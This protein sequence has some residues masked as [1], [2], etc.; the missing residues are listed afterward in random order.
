MLSEPRV[1]AALFHVNH[2]PPYCPRPLLLCC[3]RPSRAELPCPAEICIASRGRLA[4]P[5]E[6]TRL[7][8]PC[9]RRD[10]LNPS[11]QDA[12]KAWAGAPSSG[13]SAAGLPSI[14]AV[15]SMAA[16]AEESAGAAGVVSR[17]SAEVARPHPAPL[18]AP[19]K[20]LPRPPP[21]GGAPWL[22]IRP[23]ASEGAFTDTPNRLVK[24]IASDDPPPV[25]HEGG[26]EIAAE[27]KSS[28]EPESGQA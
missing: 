13:S 26:P 7:S 20:R 12:G 16:P 8:R 3:A 24:V 2:R 10:G 15:A 21:L 22:Y 6:A 19:P 28:P 4:L 14:L 11:P 9:S 18:G 27:R 5:H 1:S 17:E 23:G 25:L